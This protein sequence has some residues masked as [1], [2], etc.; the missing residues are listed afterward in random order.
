[1]R[2]I[3]LKDLTETPIMIPLLIFLMIYLHFFMILISKQQLL[4]DWM[5]LKL[6]ISRLIDLKV[7]F[8]GLDWI[9]LILYVLNPQFLQS[10]RLILLDL[11]CKFTLLMEQTQFSLLMKCFVFINHRSH[12]INHSVNQVLLHFQYLL[13]SQVNLCSLNHWHNPDILSQ[14]LPIVSIAQ[15]SH[16]CDVCKANDSFCSS[17]TM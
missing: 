17:L 7:V 5:I 6:F 15:V 2:L 11:V 8:K 13:F 3:W 16:Y 14:D 10:I 1:M 12:Q 4:D 9:I